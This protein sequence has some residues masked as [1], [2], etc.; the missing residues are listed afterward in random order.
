MKTEEMSNKELLE[1]F[2]KE[3]PGEEYVEITEEEY[4][5]LLAENRDYIENMKNHVEKLNCLLSD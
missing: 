2:K 1:L 3:H 5:L 4:E